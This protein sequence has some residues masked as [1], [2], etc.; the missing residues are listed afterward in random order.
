MQFGSEA[1]SAL[2]PPC[3]WLG[4]LRFKT[5][6]E[7]TISILQEYMAGLPV[8][9]VAFLYDDVRDLY[10]ALPAPSDEALQAVLTGSP[11]RRRGSSGRA[12]SST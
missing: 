9:D 12:T 11:T 3:L 6:R 10:L 7:A 2:L 1:D 5:Q 8:E 4:D